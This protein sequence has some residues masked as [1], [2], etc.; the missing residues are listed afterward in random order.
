M[1]GT[2]VDPWSGNWDPTRCGVTKPVCFR[3]HESQG[4]RPDPAW[5]KEDPACHHQDPMEPKKIGLKNDP[6]EKNTLKNAVLTF[7]HMLCDLHLSSFLGTHK[8]E[9]RPTQL[10]DSLLCIWNGRLHG[11]GKKW[12]QWQ[13]LSFW[14][15][16]P[17]L[18]VA[19]A[20]KWKDTCSLEGKLWPT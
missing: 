13:T 16:K 9:G 2:W 12:E 4:E 19:A 11:D 1:Q 18:I 5:C 14:A 15:P 17:L 20:T 7:R 10:F 6:H 8:Y 3:A